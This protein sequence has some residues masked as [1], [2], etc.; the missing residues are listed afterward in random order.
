MF[1][2]LKTMRMGSTALN[3]SGAIPLK[4]HYGGIKVKRVHGFLSGF[5][6]GP[7]VPA[8]ARLFNNE[9]C[10]DFMFLES[11]LDKEKA[12]KILGEIKA[13]LERAVNS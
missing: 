5:D 3:Y 7:E 2:R 11:D 4:P 12:G 9:L 1:V 13:I 8:Q 6:L 10:M